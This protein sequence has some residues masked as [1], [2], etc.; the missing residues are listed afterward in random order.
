MSM[1]EPVHLFSGVL[2]ESSALYPK[3][4]ASGTLNPSYRRLEQAEQDGEPLTIA[5][6]AKVSFFTRFF[7]SQQAW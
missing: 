1:T 6:A 3:D 7:D 4:P 2:V 5:G